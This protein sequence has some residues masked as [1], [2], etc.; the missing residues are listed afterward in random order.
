[1]CC[2][3]VC[4]EY[5]EHIFETRGCEILIDAL[6]LQECEEVVF[7]CIDRNGPIEVTVGDNKIRVSIDIRGIA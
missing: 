2:Q 6:S 5:R 7:K 3:N 1:M 4:K